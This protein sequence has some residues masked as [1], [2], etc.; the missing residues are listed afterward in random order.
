MNRSSPKASA[1]SPDWLIRPFESSKLAPPWLGLGLAIAFS[2]FVLLVHVLAN[3]TIGPVELPFGPARHAGSVLVNGALVGL[4]FTGHAQ[5]HLGAVSDLQQLRPMLSES[6]DEFARLKHEFPNLSSRL[7]WFTTAGG[8]LGGLAVASLDPTLQQFYAQV[9]P[10]DPRYLVYLIQN[11]LFGALGTR[12]FAAEIHLTRAYARLGERVEVDL[13]DLSK[14]LIFA[15]KGLRSVVIWV[16][17][18]SAFSMFWVLDSAGQANAWLPLAVLI[19]VIVALVAPTLGIHRSI[20]TAKGKELA[21]LS[22]AI[23]TERAVALAPRRAD[24]RPEDARLGNLIQYQS[25]IKSLREWPFDL[26]IV[27]RSLLLIVLGAGSWLGG[28]IVE[29]LLN[30][31]LD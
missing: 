31:L 2:I 22:E 17:I 28:A 24:A 25:F 16:L 27:S 12:L 10:T 13:L 11:I 21:L 26:S 14:V 18:S 30:V 20:K 5:L 6:D 29:R 3:A 7:R 9:A 23:R 15:R 1:R 4:I 19:L 8:G